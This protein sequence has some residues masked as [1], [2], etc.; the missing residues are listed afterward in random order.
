MAIWVSPNTFYPEVVDTWKPVFKR[1]FLP[2]VS[3]EDAF[4]AQ[5]TAISFPSVAHTPVKQ[6]FQNYEL[7]K[8]A[9]KQLDHMMDKTFTITCKLTESYITYFMA[10]Q[11]FDL[12]LKFGEV[13]KDLYIPPISVTILDDGG[14]EII[15][16]TYSELT[17]ISLSEFDLS[18]AARPGTFNTFTWTFAYNYFDI[19]YRDASGKRVKLCTDPNDGVLKD[20]GLIN[21]S[22]I[23]DSHRIITS[24]QGHP[25][26]KK[27]NT[28]I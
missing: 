12:F 21:V 8:R 5:I 20:K 28:T 15:T 23:S 13:A 14:F 10:R 17:P 19:W 26:S 18:Y 16:Y 9:G 4:N 24:I 2:Y 22:S 11:Q 1:L 27:L 25:D 3:L 7:T 6:G